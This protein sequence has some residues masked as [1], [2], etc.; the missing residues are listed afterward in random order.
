MPVFHET[1]FL[2]G[3]RKETGGLFVELF[4]DAIAASIKSIT[5]SLFKETKDHQD[6][7]EINYSPQ[8]IS[9]SQQSKKGDYSIYLQSRGLESGEN[10]GVCVGV[11]TTVPLGE[12]S[13]DYEILLAMLNLDA[14]VIQILGVPDWRMLW[15]YDGRFITQFLHGKFKPFCNFSM[16][17]P[18]Y[19]HDISFWVKGGE[20]FDEVEFHNLVRRVSKECVTDIQLLD[21]FQ[22]LE[23]GMVSLCY[24]LT[25]QSCDKALS[26]VQASTMQLQLR[27]EL[28]MFLQVIV[29]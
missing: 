17:P 14:L 13:C 6:E 27:Q 7:Q 8:L 19:V 9:F 2:C 1:L 20:Q 23:T 16:H 3:L 26:D 11:I 28:Q 22:H 5:D 15:T 29:R 25:Y 4:M 24:R 18:S 21:R 12:L 10:E